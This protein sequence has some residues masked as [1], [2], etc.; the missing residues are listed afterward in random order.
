MSTIKEKVIIK[1]I[2]NYDPEAIGDFT[3]Q[4]IETLGIKLSARTFIKPNLV[5]GPR[6]AEHAYTHVDFMRGVVQGLGQSGIGEKILYEDCGL[7]VP[8]RYVAR[9]S[10]YAKL[11]REEGLRF[12]NLS[13]SVFDAS[14][15]VPSG[16]VHRQLP[17]P[18]I[19]TREGLRVF[20]PKLKVH[21]QTDITGASKLL[22]GIIKRSIRL[23]RHHYDLGY[24]IA[25][26]LAAYPP[27]LVLIDA[28]TI[29]V[30]GVGCPDPRNLGVVIASRNA[31]AADAVAA[32]LL[33]FLP[34]EIDHLKIASERGLG[35]VDLNGIEIINP[36][37]VKP[38]S[39]GAFREKPAGELNSYISYFEGEVHVDKQSGNSRRCRGGCI[40]FVSESVH[41]INHYRDW[42]ESERTNLAARAL[43]WLLGQEPY[44]ERPRK[45]GVVVGSYKGRIPDELK[46]SL[47]FVGDCTRAD[48]Y[49]PMVHLKGCPV[50]MARK[51]FTFAARSHL[52]NPYIDVMEGIPFIRAFMEEQFM[53]VWNIATYHLRRY[54]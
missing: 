25:D 40:G 4:A 6:Y 38:A 35:P 28:I 33:G 34:A 48:G 47:I 36:D 20:V 3:A 11:C 44:Q 22:I 51:A 14:L 50:Y 29:G 30:N 32:W 7:M 8:L 23:R 9:R 27:D 13:E 41:Y 43:F 52:L 45:V 19:L 42:R 12:L 17:L 2:E 46:K 10:G 15:D 21:S 49:K 31:V 1:R 37:G 24:K 16:Q 54:R 39:P 26:A 18:S 5:H 53:R